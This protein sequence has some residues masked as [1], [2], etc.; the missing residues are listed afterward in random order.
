[1]LVLR[2]F[3]GRMP[4][5]RLFEH[6]H[7]LPHRACLAGIRHTGVYL[8]V[9]WRILATVLLI[10][11]CAGIHAQTPPEKSN[12]APSQAEGANAEQAP[13]RP[14]AITLEF[15]DEGDRWYWLEDA[16]GA[17]LAPPTKT[18]DKSVKLDLPQN[19][20]TLWV[21]DASKGNLARL[22]VAD[23]SEKTEINADKWSHV[24]RVQVN[25][26]AQNGNPVAS[27]LV[28]LTDSQKTAHRAL[29]EPTSEGIVV[30]ER[31][32][33]G[34]GELEV[35]YGA[36]ESLKQTVDLKRERD[37]RV[38]NLSVS[39]AGEVATVAPPASGSSPAEATPA[40]R[41]G[42]LVLYV[43]SGAL[44]IAVLFLLVK[45]ARQKEQ[46][47]AE[48]MQKLGVPI[49][50]SQS[51]G[52]SASIASAAAPPAPPLPP[53]DSAGVALMATA[54]TFLPEPARRLVGTQGIY[55]G[56]S[57]DLQADLLTIGREPT[58]AIALVDDS[59]VSRRHA[60]IIRQ[61]DQVEI[62]DLG[63]TNGTYVNGIRISSPTPLQTGDTVQIGSTVFRVE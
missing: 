17:P 60:Q 45:L 42:A 37:Q 34:K 15:S 16:K 49:P 40:S 52:G 38:P 36:E 2:S 14:T 26:R 27:A 61:G 10:V 6:P 48:A 23:L 22:K 54:T 44:G 53:L 59:A 63:S 13:K 8:R 43:I 4:V 19:A 18:S 33:L 21:L 32:A 55:A 56:R 3:T 11:G 62:E 30:L 50:D 1:M 9:M 39:I 24:A 29:I 12:G 47:L 20:E 28:V 58:N 25:V 41:I 31:V 5:V 7:F 35:R 51:G 46:P 57:F